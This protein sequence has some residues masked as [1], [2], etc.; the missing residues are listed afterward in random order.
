VIVCTPPASHVALARQALASG[1]H[2]LCEKPLFLSSA[3]A[4]DVERDLAGAEGLLL[5]CCSNR[6]LRSESLAKARE[7]IT[8]GR[9]GPL[10]RVRWRARRNRW[11]S[12]IEYQP[13]S[14]WFLDRRQ[15]GGGVTMDWAPYDFAAMHAI[16]NPC[17][18]TVVSCLMTQ[19]ETGVALEPGTVF[20]VETQ[21]IAQ[22]TYELAG[23]ETVRVDYE[24]AS[25]THGREEMVFEVEGE[26]GALDLDWVGKPGIRFSHDAAGK[27]VWEEMPL[28]PAAGSVHDCPIQEMIRAVRGEPSATIANEDALFNF[29][30]LRALYDVCESG[31]AV[32][33]ERQPFAAAG[34]NR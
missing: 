8:A 24:R 9:G 11:R 20:D 21:V 7:W 16:L 3:E 13:G 1:R 19:I 34:G 26:R 23:G 5:A 17:R 25:A 30:C 10:Y 12:G 15:S 28:E 31:R 32:T 6:F 18:V 33:I 22:M 2:V 4:D 29:R 27:L 14:R